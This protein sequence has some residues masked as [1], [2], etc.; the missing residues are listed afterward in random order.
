MITSRV[1]WLYGFG[2]IAYGVKD[3]GFSYFLLFYYNQVL[4][5]PGTYAGAA[6]LIAMVF[7]AVS[8]PLVGMWSDNTHSRWGRRHPFMYASAV[9]VATVY[10]FLWNPPE[11]SDFHLFIYLTVAA[12]LIRFFITLYE[13][14]S[15]AIVAELTDDYDERTRLLSFRYMMGWYGGLTMA[16]LMWGVFMVVY[17]EGSKMT[18]QVYGAVGSVAILI[19]ILGSSAGLH[20]YIPFLKAPPQRD[21]YSIVNLARDLKVTISNRNF[22]AL[23]FAGLF[24]AIAGGVSTNFN[25]YINLHFWEFSPEQVRWIIV[26]LFASAALAA[27]LA[28]KLT[29]RFD[30]KRSAMGIYGLGIV[31]GAAPVLL[32]LAGLFPENDSQYLYPIMI[33]HAMFDVTLIVMFGI[34]Q[35]SM[36]ADIVEDSEIN[37]G[38]REEGLFFAARTFASKA[39]SGV[40]AFIAGIALDY[41]HFPKDAAPGEVPADIIWD[42]GFIYG[43]SL[44]IFYLMALGAISFYKITRAGHNERIGTLEAKVR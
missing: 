23:F 12:I 17:G 41:I 33:L 5:L 10:Y 39:T 2:S 3:N 15:S 34:V 37:T 22:G 9:P 43:P 29:R 19:S 28:P 7:D 30:K 21:S 32:R 36:L 26:S 11:L 4:G 27:F 42:L 31:F 13:I 6:I 35:S 8:D 18:F 40:G 14:P 1:R 44:I 24:A 25:A 20:R 38:R 16:L